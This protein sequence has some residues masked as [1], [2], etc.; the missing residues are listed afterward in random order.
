MIDTCTVRAVIVVSKFPGSPYREEVNK[1]LLRMQELGRMEMLAKKWIRLQDSE[2]AAHQ[3][4]LV[5][6]LSGVL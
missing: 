3:D 5:G 1:G 6:W 4:G 2:C